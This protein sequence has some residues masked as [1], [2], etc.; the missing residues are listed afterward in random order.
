[1]N[2]IIFFVLFS[3]SVVL[4]DE[5]CR[6]VTNMHI[7]FLDSTI[8]WRDADS[9]FG[10]VQTLEDGYDCSKKEDEKTFL[11]S[12]TYIHRK[13]YRNPSGLREMYVV[14]SS[15]SS[16]K[17]A[18]VLKDEFMHWHRCQMLDM[19]DEQADSVINFWIEKVDDYDNGVDC[20]ESE[21]FYICD[22]P[23]G[24]SDKILQ[25]R[26][27]SCRAEGVEISDPLINK[28][29]CGALDSL[30]GP[31]WMWLREMCAEAGYNGFVQTQKQADVNIVL[32]NGLVQI[33]VALRG[34]KYY[35]FDMNGKIVQNGF[36]GNTIRLSMMPAILKIGKV[37]PILLK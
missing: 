34:E 17:L 23:T 2:K 6:F 3:I 36:A 10:F 25:W 12:N 26:N 7:E 30:I 18:D 9:F 4:A 8:W 14:Q 27:Q 37:K 35:L 28:N 21:Q 5:T 19:T 20:Y 15:L 24:V 16:Y 32:D 33:P 31:Q 13:M 11:D 22:N 1:M 29:S